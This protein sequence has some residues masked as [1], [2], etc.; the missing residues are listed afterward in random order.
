MH[1][2]DASIKEDFKHFVSCKEQAVWPSISL[3]G[4]AAFHDLKFY[5]TDDQDGQHDDCLEP[6]RRAV[7]DMSVVE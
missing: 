4:Q 7:G 1:I 2:P 6:V 3:E 5:W